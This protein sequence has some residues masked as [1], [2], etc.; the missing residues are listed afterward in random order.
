M[1]YSLV[2]LDCIEIERDNPKRPAFY[3]V[4]LL[5]DD[6]PL[7]FEMKGVHIPY[8][9]HKNKKGKMCLRVRFEGDK[10]WKE[11]EFV[12]KLNDRIKDRFPDAKYM[13]LITTDDVLEATLSTDY[14][15]RLNVIITNDKGERTTLSDVPY[16]VRA[17]VTFSIPYVWLLP[18]DKM[19]DGKS[20]LFGSLIVVKK[21]RFFS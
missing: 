17:D 16:N 1:D 18:K 12:T 3:S 6:E 9:T 19:K 15:Q 20:D 2:Q 13:P 5:G 8:G 4:K 10:Y 11:R 21:I 14:R 7:T